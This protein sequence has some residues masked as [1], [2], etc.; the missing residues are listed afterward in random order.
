MF[1]GVSQNRCGPMA[2]RCLSLLLFTTSYLWLHGEFY[3][4]SLP[5]PLHLTLQPNDSCVSHMQNIFTPSKT[6]KV[7]PNHVIRLEAH[8]LF[9]CIK[10]RY[11]QASMSATWAGITLNRRLPKVYPW[12][13]KHLPSAYL[14]P[15]SLRSNTSIWLILN[16]RVND[17]SSG[18]ALMVIQYYEL[19]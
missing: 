19:T 2:V 10:F 3:M 9:T 12:G 7:S 16:P 17:A 14:K 11:R 1:L 8:D 15:G 18:N 13:P 6:P 4:F 5:Q